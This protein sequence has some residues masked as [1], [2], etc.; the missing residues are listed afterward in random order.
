MAG[1]DASG[2]CVGASPSSSWMEARPISNSHSYG[3][4][5]TT[6][7]IDEGLNEGE[8]FSLRL[9]DASED[10]VLTWW[11][12]RT[13]GDILHRR[14]DQHQWCT[15]SQPS[16]IRTDPLRFPHRRLQRSRRHQLTCPELSSFLRS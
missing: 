6:P 7:D 3:D 15:H 2:Q 12:S 13:F 5:G 4:D 8:S 16:A 11:G 10:T 14:L 9:Y 1:F